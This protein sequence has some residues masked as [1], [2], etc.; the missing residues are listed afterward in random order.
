MEYL[1][2]VGWRPIAALSAI[3]ATYLLTCFGL[4]RFQTKLIFFPP[5]V[6]GATPADV[7]TPYE[8]LRLAAGE[9]EVHGW[10]IPAAAANAP[11]IIYA[12]GNASNLSDLVF[13][14][15]QFHDWGY[16]VMAIDYRGYGESSGPFPN[17]QRVYEDIEAAWHYLIRQQEIAASKIVLY[18]QSI[19]GAI[20]LNLAINHP[21]AAGLIM[22]SAFTSMRDMVDYRFPLLPKL[23]PIDGL[24]TQR[25]E[26]AQKMRSLKVPLLLI[27]GTDDDVVPVSM[28]QELYGETIVAGNTSSRLILIEGGDHNSLPTS[29]GNT[30]ADNI[31]GFIN[32]HT[33]ERR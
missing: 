20:A 31:Q 13:R 17:E 11:V 5:R 24:L 21:D 12:H 8:D 9:G 18:G 33:R 1:R 32:V 30:Y 3:L 23:V 19:G 25:F 2:L 4:W 10:W 28:S 27:H 22:E 15:Q 26:S 29:G 16:A 7:G 14:F 6:V